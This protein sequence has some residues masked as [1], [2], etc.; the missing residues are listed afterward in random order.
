MPITSAKSV[1]SASD[2]IP[3]RIVMPRDLEGPPGARALFLFQNGLD[4][5]YRLHHT[6]ASKAISSGCIRVINEDVIE[7]HRRA[8]VVLARGM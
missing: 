5:L 4:T 8:R 2:T 7:L 6:N 3:P 1:S